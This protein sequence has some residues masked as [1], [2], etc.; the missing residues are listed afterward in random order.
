MGLKLISVLLIVFNILLFLIGLALAGIGVW[1]VVDKVYVADVIGDDLFS[2]ASYL[3]ILGGVIV[4]AISVV[5]ICAVRKERRLLVIVYFVLLLVI[6]VV[7][8]LA[9]ILAVAFKSELEEEMVDAMRDS[10]VKGYGS[11]SGITQ[12]WDRLQSDLH[13]CGVR[14]VIGGAVV[15]PGDN[16]ERSRQDSWLLFRRTRWYQAAREQEIEPV[17]IVPASCCVYD[18]K[19][20]GYIDQTKCQ[21]WELGPPGNLKSGYNNNALL[22]RGCYEQAQGFLGEQADILVACAFAF[23]FTMI[24]GLV[25][26]LMLYRVL[27]QQTREIR[28]PR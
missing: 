22:Y 5:G 19:I 12:S 14:E 3:L 25:L 26:T 23:A 1:S 28:D 16:T 6:F 10:L 7:I 2:A 9:A 20:R 24:G 8:L 27:G 4:L 11:D 18:S 21:T 15:S 17:E 13:C